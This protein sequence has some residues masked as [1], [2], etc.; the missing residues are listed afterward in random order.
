MNNLAYNNTDTV[1]S[2][3]L[4][5]LGHEL[6]TPLNAIIG[7]SELLK[8]T[9]TVGMTQ[10]QIN[11]YACY[12]HD[13]GSHLLNIINDILEISRIN[14]QTAKLKESKVSVAQLL[15]VPMNMLKN[16]ADKKI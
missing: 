13:S 7:F 3:F 14:N 8:K 1:H 10:D 15:H 6:K 11:E 4:A 9:D 5:T 2:R 16:A 12:I